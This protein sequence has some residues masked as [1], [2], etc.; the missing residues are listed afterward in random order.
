MRAARPA[1]GVA[2]AALVAAAPLA[3]STATAVPAAA[4]A[5]VASAVTSTVPSHL[6]TH[7]PTALP[8]LPG[9]LPTWW[10]GLSVTPQGV[11]FDPQVA[12]PEAR[13]RYSVR[14]VA[15]GD[16]LGYDAR[17][18]A[19]DSSDGWLTFDQAAADLPG[20]Y[21]VVSVRVP[22]VPQR[23]S[24]DAAQPQCTAAVAAATPTD[25]APAPPPEPEPTP[26][27][28]PTP[29]PTPTPTPTPTET[30]T[31][32]P[33]PTPAPTPSATALLDDELLDSLDRTEALAVPAP[34]D[35][36][37]SHAPLLLVGAAGLLAAAV[38]A[39]LLARRLR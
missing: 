21:C 20:G 25:T 18:S 26:T 6:P 12:V 28:T 24:E 23:W 38:G 29:E 39:V 34:A 7:L 19:A 16:V 2:V 9:W 15:G 10:D 27:P 3:G 5:G 30:P 1:L 37:A 33:T 22:G 17:Y 14:P 11:A 35:P 8:G 4:G 32:T 13:L 31:P 36:P